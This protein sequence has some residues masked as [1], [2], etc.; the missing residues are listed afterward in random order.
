MY[1]NIL[2]LFFKYYTRN[3]KDFLNNNANIA[4]I[5]LLNDEIKKLKNDLIKANKIIKEQNN[6]I[7]E[8]RDKLKN[9]Y[10]NISLENELKLK[11]K[12]ND[13]LKFKLNNI[14]IN[15]NE[16]DEKVGRK[17]L[18]C[19]NFI[20]SDQSIH[21]SI[22]CISSDIFA[23]IEEKLYKQFPKYRETNNCFLANGKEILRFKSISENNI[24]NGFP[25]ILFAPNK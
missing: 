12:E 11:D 13:E 16:N 18:Q 21:Y 3:Y 20:S 7:R 19:V 8:L 22:P 10:S 6:T 23:E 4:N 17:E 5:T 14:N 9:N 2:F 1:Y 15:L 24:G 25:V